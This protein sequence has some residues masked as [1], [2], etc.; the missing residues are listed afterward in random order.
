[1]YKQ[2]ASFSIHKAYITLL[3]VLFFSTGQTMGGSPDSTKQL[4][5]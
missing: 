3:L 1:M 5:L 4:D 2:S